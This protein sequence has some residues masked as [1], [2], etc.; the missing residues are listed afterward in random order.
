MANEETKATSPATEPKITPAVLRVSQKVVKPKLQ[1]K[2]KAGLPR[3]Q[4]KALQAKNAR[5][6]KAAA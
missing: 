4:K 1:P 2:N 3:R 5:I 6:V